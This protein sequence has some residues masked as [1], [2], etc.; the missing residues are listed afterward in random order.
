MEAGRLTLSGSIFNLLNDG[1]F[2]QFS[3]SGANQRYNPNFLQMF[4]LNPPRA[5][6]VEAVFR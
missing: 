2:Y 4:N 6:Q 5:L 1:H 3:F